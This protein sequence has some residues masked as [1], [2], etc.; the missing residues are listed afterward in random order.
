M[1]DGENGDHGVDIL[2]LGWT[3]RLGRHGGVVRG[4]GTGMGE[5]EELDFG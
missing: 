4:T 2:R 1:D 3:W 5:E